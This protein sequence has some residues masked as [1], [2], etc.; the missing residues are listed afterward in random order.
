MYSVQVLAQIRLNLASVDQF[1]TNACGLADDN[2]DIKESVYAAA[3]DARASALLIDHLRGLFSRQHSMEQLE[4][5]AASK[6][7][8]AKAAAF[9]PAGGQPQQQLQLQ[10]L[11]LDQNSQLF[12]YS[13]RLTLVRAAKSLVAN[14]AKILYFTDSIALKSSSSQQQQ[15]QWR[16]QQH[17]EAASQNEKVSRL[18]LAAHPS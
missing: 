3:K 8:R 11:K 4:L 9:E 12:T 10:R 2:P 1:L 14:V 6:F 16:L 5:E 18:A 17:L 15:Q 13:N 7:L